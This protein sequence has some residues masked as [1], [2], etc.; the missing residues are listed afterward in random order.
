MINANR[1]GNSLLRRVP[2]PEAN[3]EV[4]RFIPTVLNMAP[5]GAMMPADVVLTCFLSLGDKIPKVL[6]KTGKIPR[7]SE[8]LPASRLTDK[9]HK[10]VP[11][12]KALLHR[13]YSTIKIST[14]DLHHFLTLH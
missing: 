3:K 9:T 6:N 12:P 4:L 7:I 2:K 8:S 13:D 10:V 14:D 5:M 1:S 11:G